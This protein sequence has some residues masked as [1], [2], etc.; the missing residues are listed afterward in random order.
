MV[1]ITDAYGF[2]SF[3]N[4]VNLGANYS[5]TTVFLDVDI[6]LS[7]KE[8]LP[9][10]KNSSTYFLGSFD[11][12]GHIINNFIINAPIQYLGL[13]GY[14]KGLSIRNVVLGD[15]CSFTSTF[16]GSSMS[17]KPY[18][19]GIIGSVVGPVN[20]ENSVNMA[21]LTFSGDVGFY[22]SYLGGIVG[23]LHCTESVDSYIKNCANYGVLTHDG[24]SNYQYIGGIMGYNDISTTNKYIQNCAN[25]GV[26]AFVEVK[27]GNTNIGGIIGYSMGTSIENCVSAGG[28]Y[29]SI[30]KFI[31]TIAG[32]TST[33]TNISNCYYTD[34][35]DGYNLYARG[36]PQ[37]MTNTPNASTTVNSTLV[38][39]LN[40]YASENGWSRWLLNANSKNAT[41]V[42]N[43]NGGFSVT[44]QAIL[45]PE[46]ATGYE[47]VF[48]GWF[49]DPS[50]LVSFQ[51]SEIT[52]S[53]SL[54]CV[55]VSTVV[56]TFDATGGSVLVASKEVMYSATY[57]EL[58][59][60]IW[61]GCT[62]DGWFSENNVSVTSGS[63][64]SIPR[65][66]TLY[67]RWVRHNFTLTFDFGNGTVIREIVKFNDEI[68]YPAN[69]TKEGYSFGGWDPAPKTMPANDLNIAAIWNVNN[70][71]LTVD[72]NN[73]DAIEVRSLEFNASIDY[74][75]GFKRK[76]HS[77]DG[78][79]N[80]TEFMPAY[81]LTVTAKWKKSSKTTLIVAIVVPICVIIIAAV[82]AV[83][84]FVFYKKKKNSSGSNA[85]GKYELK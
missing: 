63:T 27:P 52:E 1:S 24:V 81:D 36:T 59:D 76:G 35:I 64:V 72:P 83:L 57:D 23:Y 49:S 19:G 66:H 56:V 25:Y 12:Q 43:G 65:D 32:W 3:V 77:F 54:Y 46:L 21:S 20:V 79:V 2:S 74:P 40:S 58:P 75:S 44:S 70:Y 61:D 48:A 82:V 51:S 78:W 47:G 16:I 73:G 80:Y 53:M 84:F 13:F 38:S 67:A 34:E 17:E 18:I 8:L 6:D 31:G 22:Y 37:N 55:Y 62:F 5:G 28:V 71:T 7:G 60:P 45:L 50:Y 41:L 26:I 4:D 30:T 69:F 39:N 10:G 9:I 11:G 14:S 85:T 29:S 68:V 42:V 15:S 33:N